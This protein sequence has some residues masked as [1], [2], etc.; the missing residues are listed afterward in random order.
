MSA[1]SRSQLPD[2]LGLTQRGRRED[3]VARAV[4]EQIARHPVW[5]A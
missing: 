3:G 2:R 1:P 5:F 4:R